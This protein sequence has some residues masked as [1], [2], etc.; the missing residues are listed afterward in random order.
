MITCLEA[1]IEQI[2]GSGRAFFVHHKLEAKADAMA[3]EYCENA[4]RKPV[5]PPVEFATTLL[6][7]D[8]FRVSS[9]G[10]QSSQEGKGGHVHMSGFSVWDGHWP[11]RRLHGC[12]VAYPLLGYK[13][14]QQQGLTLNT[15]RQHC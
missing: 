9:K 3:T 4:R 1:S 13:T 6:L 15:V 14:L 10:R 7:I 8:S 2:E 11:V 5:V 12:K